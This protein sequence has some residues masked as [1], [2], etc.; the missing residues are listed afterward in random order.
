MGFK[1]IVI[2]PDGERAGNGIIYRTSIEALGAGR[3]L[4]SRW[5][6]PV[7]L[8]TVET[9]DAVTHSWNFETERSEALPPVKTYQL[10]QSDLRL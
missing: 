10:D 6:A 4:L 5:F 1:S 2:M 7:R 3:E 8:E 9:T